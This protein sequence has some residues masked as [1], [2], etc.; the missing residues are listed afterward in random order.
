MISCV[1]PIST[2]FKKVAGRANFDQMPTYTYRAVMT[3]AS[4]RRATG[5][6]HHEFE[7]ETAVAF[8][9]SYTPIPK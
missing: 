1:E 8:C 9:A 4:N 6:Q 7:T 2:R 5:E 3:I